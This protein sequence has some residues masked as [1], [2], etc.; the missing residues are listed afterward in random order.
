M[1]QP[2]HFARASDGVTVA[3]STFGSGRPL[4]LV[5]GWISHLELD[6]ENPDYAR[7]FE[8]LF[9]EG[10]RRLIR[11]DV[12]GTGLSDREVSDTSVASRA[13]DI[14]AVVDNMGLDSVA[15]FAWS[16]GGPAAITYAAAHPE[17]VS[18]LVLH[19][20]LAHSNEHSREALG[21]ALVDLIRADWRIGSRAIVEFVNPNAEKE[22]ADNFTYYARNSASGAI[23][24]ALL[25]EALFHVD[26]REDLGKLTMP[27]LVLH[28][29]DDQAFPLHLGRDLA[30][31]L[32]HAHFI[33][34][35]GNA[36]APFYGDISPITE[37]IADF[38]STSDG[39]TH[40]EPGAHEPH[41]EVLAG[42]LQTILFTDMESSTNM[43]IQ[44]GDSQAQELVR[45]HNSIVRGALRAHGGSE[46]KHTG[47]GIMA[48][49][50]SAARAI[51][52]AIAI[53]RGC[54]SQ[55]VEHPTAPLRMRIGLNAGEP[56]AEER[57]LFGAAV[58]LAAR[59]CASAGPGQILASDV[60]RQLAAGKRFL[61]SDQGYVAL[62]GFEDPVRL[63]E[64]KW[65]S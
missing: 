23:A 29:R 21:R 3:Y 14:E 2:I 17:K 64:V 33:P 46:I 36:H 49:F 16:M 8:A 37:A 56:V 52:C 63:Y 10:R 28:R 1:Q 24:A 47:D 58:Q 31:L 34:L 50:P 35:P 20:T 59:V 54:D 5:P 53:Q 13:R 4:L 43:T 62:R 65:R 9:H 11:L 27:T 25:E 30:S 48:A 15:I 39:H 61:W 32:P 60:V 45:A 57:D 42:G 19:G 26:V 6:M 12:R 18:H 22:V 41:T 55:A 51:D 40:G 44:L 38:L 7:F